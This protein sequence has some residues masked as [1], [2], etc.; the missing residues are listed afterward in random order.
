MLALRL[1]SSRALDAYTGYFLEVGGDGF[2]EC[3]NLF[4][5]G[6]H[7]TDSV[8]A[9]LDGEA[10]SD[11]QDVRCGKIHLGCIFFNILERGDVSKNNR[12][13]MGVL[14]PKKKL[15]PSGFSVEKKK[16]MV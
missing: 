10:G 13:A 6:G 4:F 15:L 9:G 16:S 12:R 2:A 3:S 5:T 14:A 8:G 1:A 11:G 7:D